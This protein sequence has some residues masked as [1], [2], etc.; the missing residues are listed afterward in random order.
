MQRRTRFLAAALAATT[1]LGLIPSAA[2]AAPNPASLVTFG[3][4]GQANPT[5]SFTP[6]GATPIRGEF[7]GQG[8]EDLIW[9]TPGAGGDAF[10]SGN[11]DGTWDATALSVSGTY[12]PFVGNFGNEDKGDDVLW[13]STTGA[14]QLWSYDGDGGMAKTSLPDVT[15]TGTILIGDFTTDGVQDIVRYRPGAQPEVW[16][17]FD[18]PDDAAVAVTSRSF[19]VNGT[20][21]PLVGSFYRNPIAG[22]YGDDI[23]WY[24]PGAAADTLWDFEPHATYDAYPMAINGTFKPLVGR[25][26]DSPHDQIL[27]YAAGSAPDSL[28]SFN[29]AHT[30]QKKGL[31][32]NGT[33]TPYRCECIKSGQ[34]DRDDI[35][36]HGAGNAPDAIWSNKG[37]AFNPTSY[38]YPGTTIRGSKLALP[39]ATDAFQQSV[40]A[41]G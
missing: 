29:E 3:P 8:G 28:W 19:N 27:W 23:L 35:V 40:L 15:G 18:D 5:E 12:T 36:W 34:G 4:N 16:W 17:D 9:Y 13:Y 20:Y 21:T 7:D 26:M 10:W 25:F 38:S 1:A 33:Y 22:D 39:Y 2:T 31:T 32:I 37:I 41:Y 14:S 11:G 6:P 24:A 30:V